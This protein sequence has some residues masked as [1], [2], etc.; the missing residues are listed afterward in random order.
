MGPGQ[1]PRRAQTQPASSNTFVPTGAIE[2][3]EQVRDALLWNTRAGIAHAQLH[4]AIDRSRNQPHPAA[5]LIVLD[6]ILE[7]ILGNHA[8][9]HSIGFERQMGGNI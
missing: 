3:L 4:L 7:K 2:A 5:L 9:K 8:D 6:R 1:F